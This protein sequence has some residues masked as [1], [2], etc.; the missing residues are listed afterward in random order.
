MAARKQALADQEA[1]WTETQLHPDVYLRLKQW[2][3][4]QAAQRHLPPY[5]ILPSKTLIAI[6]NLLP[7]NLEQL[8]RVKGVGKKKLD[9]YGADILRLVNLKEA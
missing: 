6:A 8:K 9:Q 3:D 5:L 4:Q 1:A 2:R 7:R